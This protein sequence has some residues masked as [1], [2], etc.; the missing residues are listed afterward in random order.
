M[1]KPHFLFKAAETGFLPFI[2]EVPFN[3]EIKYQRVQSEKTVHQWLSLATPL[4]FRCF[5]CNP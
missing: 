2:E 5:Y 1:I 4:N 3:L